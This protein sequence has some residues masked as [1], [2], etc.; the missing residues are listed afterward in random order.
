MQRIL[1]LAILLI[2]T[3]IPQAAF[4][5]AAIN[6]EIA[7][8]GKLRVAMNSA[9]AVLLKRTPDGKITGGVGLELGK[10][11]AGKLGAVLSW[12]PTPTR[13]RTRR[14]SAR[15]NGILDSGQEHR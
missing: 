5:Q 14:P 3:A 7:P 15:E 6:S 1:L 9:T 4:G 2:A 8:A 12:S 13:T 11:M 10:F